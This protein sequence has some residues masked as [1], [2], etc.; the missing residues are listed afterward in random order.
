MR[1]AEKPFALLLFFYERF[2]DSLSVPKI[3]KL[4]SEACELYTRLTFTGTQIVTKRRSAEAKLAKKML[5]MVF[6]RR[7]RAMVKMIKTEQWSR[8]TRIKIYKYIP[9]V[10]LLSIYSCYHFRRCP[11]LIRTNR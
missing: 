3:K 9:I 11:V 1:D 8:K 7:K 5:V 10:L 4:P 6:K 2:D